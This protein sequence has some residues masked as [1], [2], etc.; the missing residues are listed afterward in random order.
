MENIIIVLIYIVF[1]FLIKFILGIKINDVKKIK[2]IGYNKEL[3]KI[4]D[5]LPPNKQI[6]K[7]ILKKLENEN[8]KIEETESKEASLYIVATNTILISDIKDTFMRVQTIAHECL[9]SIQNKKILLFNFI[10]SNIYIIYCLAVLILTIF[11]K[12]KHTALQINIL[13][14][15]GFIY[16]IIRSYLETDAMIKAEYLAKEYM[17]ETDKLTKEE[18]EIIIKN[19]KKVNQKGIQIVNF[20][21]LI[22]VISKVVIYEILSQWGRS[23]L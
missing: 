12:I 18:I 20:S 11:G 19:Y 22:S 8:V 13:I 1:I 6:C 23:F 15:L 21:L 2:E 7:E 10:Y 5:K 17:E 3:A 9:H 4:T 16:Y 14:I